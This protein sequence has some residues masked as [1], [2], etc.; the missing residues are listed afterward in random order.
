MQTAVRMAELM[1]TAIGAAA[2][3]KNLI[4]VFKVDGL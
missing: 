4:P 1:P 3:F 2:G